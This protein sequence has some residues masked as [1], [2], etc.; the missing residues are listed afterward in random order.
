MSFGTART[1]HEEYRGTEVGLAVLPAESGSPRFSTEHL[2]EVAPDLWTPIG[3][4][5]PVSYTREDPVDST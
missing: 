4:A 1:T 2:V 3:N 5:K